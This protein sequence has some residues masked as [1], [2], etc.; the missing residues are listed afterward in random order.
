MKIF[1]RMT[2]AAVTGIFFM[3]GIT[4]THAQSNEEA[5]QTT[6]NKIKETEKAVQ[7]KEKEKQSIN[8]DVQN[9]QSQLNSLHTVISSNKKELASTEKQISEA[10]KMIEKKKKEIVLLQEKVLSRKDIIENR[11]VAL[12]QD[13]KT[14]VVIDT[15]MNADNFG[16]FVA[17]MGAVTTLLSADNDILKQHQNDLD[18]IEKDKK[19]IDK[20][21]KVLEAA[22]GSLAAK[23][24][25]LDKNVAKQTA[26]LTTMQE[27]Y[28]TVVN[29]IDAASSKKANLQSE[30]TGIQDKI[31]KEKEAAQKQAEQVAKQQAAEKAEADAEAKRQAELAT[32]KKEVKTAAATEKKAAVSSEAKETKKEESTQKHSGKEM[33]VEATAYTANCAGCSGVTATGQNVSSGTH[34]IIAVDPSVIP[35]G[36]KVYVEG[37]GVATAGDT[38]GAIKG[39]R[40]DVLVPSESAAKAFGRRT[41]K[42][43]VLN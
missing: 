11:L 21:E 18:Q 41:V 12:Q 2:L 39:Y 33:Y 24:A 23:Q 28:S 13:D 26:T 30:L 8:S 20:Q 31:A 17:R 25:E 6:E 38:G 16:D 19:E 40:I 9:I 3:T 22:K 7:Q 36:S 43:T 5:L 10:N 35:L 42:I 14:S 4:E 34:K 27:K 1:K 29:E 15:L 32:A 37:Y